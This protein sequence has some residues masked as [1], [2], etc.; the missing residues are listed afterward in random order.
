MRVS[1][2]VIQKL[3]EKTD[4]IRNVCV[5]A[6]VDHG[7]TTLCDSL[8]ASNNIISERSAGDIRYMDSRKD[9]QTRGITM[10]SSSISLHFRDQIDET[11]KIHKDYLINL[12]DS[13]GHVDFSGEVETGIKISDGCL[14][15][16]DVIR[17]IEAQTKTVLRQA[18]KEKLKPILVLNKIDRL[19]VE[20]N[21]SALEVWKHCKQ[22]LESINAEMANLAR[23]ES[24]FDQELE[25]QKNKAEDLSEALGE[26]D[27]DNDDDIIVSDLLEVID[28]QSLYFNPAKNNVIFTSSIGSWGFSLHQRAQKMTIFKNNPNL[29]KVFIKYGF[30]DVYYDKKA[31]KFVKGAIAKKKNPVFVQFIL[32]PI[33]DVFDTIVNCCDGQKTQ[34]MAD[35]MKLKM[36][37]ADLK[38]IAINPAQVLKNFMSQ[39]LPLGECVLKNIIDIIPSPIDVEDHRLK[40]LIS[41]QYKSQFSIMDGTKNADCENSRGF[42]LKKYLED[43]DFLDIDK[44]TEKINST[45]I[46]DDKS[47]NTHEN[48]FD[49]LPVATQEL[50]KSFKVPYSENNTTTPCIAFVS[51]IIALD[52]QAISAHKSQIKE[53]SAIKKREL[54]IARAK[55]RAGNTIIMSMDHENKEN[56]DKN[57]NNNGDDNDND[58][59]AQDVDALKMVALVRIYSG[60][61]RPGQELHVI[62]NNTHLKNINDIKLQKIKIGPSDLVLVQGR[63]IM[64][65]S[66][67]PVGSI[68]G[69]LNLDDNSKELNINSSITL[70]STP[71][72]SCLT[73][74]SSISKPILKV[75]LE[76]SNYKFKKDLVGALKKLSRIDPAVVVNL[77][78]N[79]DL[80]L[81]TSGEVHLEKCV[82]DLE[83]RFIKNEIHQRISAERKLIIQ[84]NKKLEEK[85]KEEED[86]VTEPKKLP[87]LTFPKSACK[88]KISDPIVDFKETLIEKPKTDTMDEDLGQQNVQFAKDLE[89]EID[90][91][92]EN[93][94]DSRFEIDGKS[95]KIK[96]VYETETGPLTISMSAWPISKNRLD[97]LKIIEVYSDNVLA[98]NKDSDDE[99]AKSLE[100]SNFAK[101]FINAFKSVVEKGPLAQEPISGVVFV[102]ETFLLPNLTKNEPESDGSVHEYFQANN[103]E[104]KTE[105]ISALRKLFYRSFQLQPQR[106]L[107]ATYTVKMTV[108]DDVGSAFVILSSRL[109]NTLD[110][111]MTD[112]NTTLILSEM[113]LIESLG[114]LDEVRSTMAGKVTAVELEFTHWSLVNEDPFWVQTTQEEIEHY[115]TVDL[116]GSEFNQAKKYLDLIRERKGLKV[117]GKK[118]VSNAEKQ[119]TMKR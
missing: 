77:K 32:K 13:P 3:Q 118:V 104:S 78:K 42:D 72:C 33:F 46:E 9:E 26:D 5:L 102:I 84:E 20:W 51:K 103:L 116:T 16:I 94:N 97:N 31:K 91:L 86:S 114:F 7:K 110:T 1:L 38:K 108:T 81:A 40:Q 76:P 18:W 75:I 35:H 6:H 64:R 80:V 52:D 17:G 55:E 112:A 99:I 36:N 66:S 14:L 19:F 63:D 92:Q 95:M 98:A 88:I 45:C 27:N 109:A 70:S 93:F 4:R 48:S 12:I 41:G 11:Q 87:K 10:K 90:L 28:D 100:N 34:E 58:K 69:I 67:L 101:I 59:D 25:Y 23:N 82:Y 2:P 15:V 79:G 117:F 54:A 29:K 106:L 60:V 39:W 83:N 71:Y 50:A 56:I 85:E 68:G 111:K 22:I 49:S 37:N 53:E 96:F 43:N 74:K 65:T 105:F 107:A 57:S 30:S 44:T 113:R 24:L 61:L 62:T 21:Y 47:K 8:I 89:L 115:G 73:D 119:R